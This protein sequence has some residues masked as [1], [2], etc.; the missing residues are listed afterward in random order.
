MLCDRQLL[1]TMISIFEIINYL[2]YLITLKIF[3]T[4]GCYLKI[5]NPEIIASKIEYY[6]LASNNTDYYVVIIFFV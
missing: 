3:R 6:L 2:R 4:G 5:S 1:I